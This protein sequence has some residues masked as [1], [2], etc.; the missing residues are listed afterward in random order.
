MDPSWFPGG[1]CLAQENESDDFTM[2]SNICR[3]IGLR[4]TN[5]MN[6]IG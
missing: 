6:I 2:F 3:I 5:N 1:S 4:N